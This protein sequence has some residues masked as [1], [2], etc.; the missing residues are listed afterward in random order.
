VGRD[1]YCDIAP[2]SA[3]TVP[4]QPRRFPNRRLV[5]TLWCPAGLVGWRACPAAVRP[6]LGA[7][8]FPA[9]GWPVASRRIVG[10]GTRVA[11][12]KS[13]EE[14]TRPGEGESARASPPSP[15]FSCSTCA[16]LIPVG[17]R[18]RPSILSPHLVRWRR[19][20]L[21]GA[22]RHKGKASH[23]KAKGKIKASLTKL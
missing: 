16:H 23:S 14:G 2:F 5:T 6:D 17:P 22:S 11:Q 18:T 21:G 3:W 12:G 20:G 19:S 13:E 10:A 1:A 9:R 15:T 4:G 8:R 7:D